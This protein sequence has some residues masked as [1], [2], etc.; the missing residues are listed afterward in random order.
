[1]FQ[2]ARLST[3]DSCICI[4]ELCTDPTRSSYFAASRGSTSACRDGD[5]L[6]GPI[7]II[8]VLL[9]VIVIIVCRIV[10]IIV[11]FAFLRFVLF[12][13]ILPAVYISRYGWLYFMTTNVVDH[14][15]P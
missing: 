13:L 9:F 7:I 2:T 1:M 14:S 8:F 4:S 3:L 10:V 11:V 5:G 6:L 12:F 15:Q